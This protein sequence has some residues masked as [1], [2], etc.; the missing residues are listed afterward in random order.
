MKW[1]R[2]YLM[3]CQRGFSLLEFLLVSAMFAVV[4]GALGAM[5]TMTRQG[6]DYSTAQA[7]IQRTGTIM[8]EWLQQ[9]L[10][11]AT[12]LQVV[13]CG[14]NT[15]AQKSVMYQT[16]M[17]NTKCIF[18]R[19]YG[20]DPGPQIYRCTM[21]SWTVGGGCTNTPE[22]LLLVLM[23]IAVPEGL[24]SKIFVQNTQFT[25]VVCLPNTGGACGDSGR[26]VVTPLVDLRFDMN[27]TG[28]LDDISNTYTG[29]RFLVS[30]AVRN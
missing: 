5:F 2:R 25:R 3:G 22:N 6:F 26:Q 19:Q 12:A 28:V 24:G 7:Q 17:G 30:F 9:E 1:M 8:Q 11:A 29:Q 4:L 13:N 10:T 18:E 20:G 27:L 15:V 23:P 16:A 21:A 14:P